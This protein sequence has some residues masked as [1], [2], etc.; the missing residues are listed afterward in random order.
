MDV[1]VIGDLYLD[2][3]VHEEVIQQC[4]ALPWWSHVTGGVGDVVMKTHPMADRAPVDVWSAKANLFLRGQLVGI[5]DGIDRHHTFLKDPSTGAPRIF[6][7]PSCQGIREYGRWKRKEIGENL[8]GEPELKNCDCMK[9]LQYGLIDHFGRVERIL[10]PQA[11][12]VGERTALPESQARLPPLPGI[13]PVP[14]P[15]RAVGVRQRQTYVVTPRP[16]KVKIG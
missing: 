6:F 11:I 16:P 14:A 9:A 10:P 15:A 8:Y 12:A 7:N 4:Q 1:W 13:A 3:A 5:D 2:H